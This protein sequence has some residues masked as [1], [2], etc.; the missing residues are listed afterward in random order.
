MAKRRLASILTLL[1]RVA[2][3]FLL[4]LALLLVYGFIRESRYRSQ[5]S[6]EQ[7]PPGRMVALD[8]HAL[9]L[10]CQGSGIPTVILEA[11]LDAIGALN[12]SLVQGELAAVSRTCSYDRAGIMWSE[13]GPRP[14]DGEQIAAE[15]KALLEAAGE[16]GPF[17]LVGH[18]AGGAYARI[19]AGQNRDSICGLLLVD[20][21]HPDQAT[22]FTETG[23]EYQVPLSQ[24]RPLVV[25]L[26][27]LGRPKRYSGPKPRTL[28]NEVYEAMQARLPQ[29]SVAWYDETVAGTAT[30]DQA[31]KVQSLGDLPLIVLSSGSRSLLHSATPG[32]DD[33]RAGSSGALARTAGRAGRVEHR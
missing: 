32:R 6:E 26:S 15:L 10:H 4:L 27:H 2:L 16:E 30:L 22:R 28:T 17:L 31:K 11:D 8:T 20:S 23:A 25:L 21:V 18:A 19:F 12:W 3:L 29:S 24:I 33:R 14:R 9:H 1:G 5:V 13:P 7:P